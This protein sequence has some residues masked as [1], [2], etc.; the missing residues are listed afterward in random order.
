MKHWLVTIDTTRLGLERCMRALLMTGSQLRRHHRIGSHPLG[1][2]VS[3]WLLVAIPEW[4]ESR[5]DE[6]CRPVER[7]EKTGVV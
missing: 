3:A 4:Q 2:G 1:R 6:I 7:R 5:F